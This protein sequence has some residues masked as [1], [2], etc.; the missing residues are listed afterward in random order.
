[1]PFVFPDANEENIRMF[2]NHLGLQDA[3]LMT[4]YDD[5]TVSMLESSERFMEWFR[6][7]YGEDAD[8][9]DMLQRETFDMNIPYEYEVMLAP[10]IIITNTITGKQRSFTDLITEC[11]EFI[12]DSDTG[13][14]SFFLY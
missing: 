5:Q 12:G 2:L 7:V 6:Q 13:N 3:E 11:C 1:M 14:R 9:Y 8:L 10:H 4:V